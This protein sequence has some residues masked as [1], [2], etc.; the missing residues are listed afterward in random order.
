MPGALLLDSYKQS[1][2]HRECEHSAKNSAE[3]TMQQPA[4]PSEHILY[5][6]LYR[7]DG[8][9]ERFGLH[10]IAVSNAVE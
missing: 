8:D 3:R 7:G 4:G 9:S 6:V 5:L 10:L 2:S 1:G